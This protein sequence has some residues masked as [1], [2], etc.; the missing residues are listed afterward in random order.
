MLTIEV[1]EP[2]AVSCIVP[3][4]GRP[5]VCTIPATMRVGSCVRNRN[6][7]C[8]RG[9]L[10]VRAPKDA[11]QRELETSMEHGFAF[12][13]VLLARLMGTADATAGPR[14]LTGKCEPPFIGR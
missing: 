8:D 13:D 7:I 14:A 9:P 4:R 2:A 5:E 3:L 1:V 6:K 11:I 10:A 12:T